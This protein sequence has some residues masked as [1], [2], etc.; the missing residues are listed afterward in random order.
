MVRLSTP[1]I[2]A[3]LEAVSE[4]LR[5]QWRPVVVPGLVVWVLATVVSVTL[6]RPGDVTEYSTYAHAALTAPLL[7]HLPNEYPAPA[8]VIFLLPL[9]IPV[10]YPW[11]FAVLTGIGLI[12]LITSYQGASIAGWDLNAARRLVA[13][14]ALGSVMVVAGRYDIFATAAALWSLRA[15]KQGRWSAAWTWSTVGFALK[16]FPAVFW[17]AFFIAEWRRTRRLPLQRLAWMAGGL[18]VVAVVPALFDPHA[19]L[20]VAH[21]YLHR[22]TEIGSVAAGVSLLFDWRSTRWV[23]TFHSLNVFNSWA[24]PV[25]MVIVV[26]ALIG[27]V[28][29]WRGQLRGRLP[30]EAVCL[31]TLTLAVVG[32]K[33]LSVQYLIWLMP[34]WALYRVRASWVAACVIN[35]A[36]FPY[37]ASAERLGH[38]HRPLAITITLAFLVRDL[39]VAIG[40][41]TWL[42][43]LRGHGKADRGV[44]GPVAV[45]QDEEKAVLQIRR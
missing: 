4:T 28:L 20:N 7:H 22:P 27:C 21:F 8:L 42:R 2:R 25:S 43:S 35:L 16:L 29:L 15:A 6:L 3:R 38:P 23:N 24:A 41:V 18:V 33:V 12:A 37:A 26:A 39:L 45:G 30:L 34:L 32:G 11:A 10:A 19:L 9:L 31:A 1:A 40:T 44:M 14:L 17:P 13:Y 5:G 36:I